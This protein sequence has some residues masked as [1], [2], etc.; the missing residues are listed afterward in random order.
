MHDYRLHVFRIVAEQL[1]F[2]RAAAILHIS[3][4]AVTQHVKQLEDHY[5][6]P[7]FVRARGGIS[8]T[9][10]GHTLLEHTVRVEELHH[11]NEQ[12]MRAGQMLVAGPLRLGAS[13]TIAQYLLPRWLGLFR[14]KHSGVQLSLRMGNTGE[15]T[16]A[17]LAG[18]V[19]LGLIEGPSGRR[20]LKT[21]RFAEDES[22]PW[23]P[24][25]TAWRRTSVSRPLT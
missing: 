6:Q 12:R 16:G 1:N 10:A 17:V 15:V 11:G 8:L 22:C 24:P 3:Q 4:P 7:L 18:R 14:R 13:T 19:D 23:S 9:P 5:G 2:T 20:E 21:E 25:G